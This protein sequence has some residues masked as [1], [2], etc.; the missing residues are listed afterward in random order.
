MALDFARAQELSGKQ[1][2]RTEMEQQPRVTNPEEE[3]Y[4]DGLGGRN[5]PTTKECFSC[6]GVFPHTGGKNQYPA[7]GK[8]AFYA[9][10]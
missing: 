5:N 9:G 2:K 6:G 4:K 3:L 8:N 10:E 1:A 7:W